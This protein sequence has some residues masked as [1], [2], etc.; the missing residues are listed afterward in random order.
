MLENQLL[1]SISE[2]EMISTDLKGGSY[3]LPPSPIQWRAAVK[4]RDQK[5]SAAYASF[6]C[7]II[8]IHMQA[9]F[10]SRPRNSSQNRHGIVL[11][12]G[13]HW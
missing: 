10:R 7:C 11:H 12:G 9:S 3:V 2:I 5:R 13:M 4:R 1:N 6:K 8:C